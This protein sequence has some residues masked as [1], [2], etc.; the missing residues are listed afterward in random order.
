MLKKLLASG[1]IFM[2]ALFLVSGA[3]FASPA[4]DNLTQDQQNA[5]TIIEKA[6]KEIDEKIEKAVAEAD[7][8]QEDYLRDIQ[9][10]KQLQA[11]AELNP[12]SAQISADVAEV[13]T[14][15]DELVDQ[16]FTPGGADSEAVQ[17]QI[18]ELNEKV[19]SEGTLIAERTKIY[20]S[21][22]DKLVTDLYNETL[23]IAD[24]A[25]AQA[26]ELGVVA[27]R[28]WKLVKIADREVWIDPIAI[29]L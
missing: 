13:K 11:A 6:N 21:A 16:L 4:A 1:S 28:F 26:A 29:E 24:T 15:S 9:V 27:E 14:A 8:L 2:L 22:L 10:I 20:T 12:D 19:S 3:V 25:I 17:V 5:L 18:A 23:Q 7:K